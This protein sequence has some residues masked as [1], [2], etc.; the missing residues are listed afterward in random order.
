MGD[1]FRDTRSDAKLPDA[2]KLCKRGKKKKEILQKKKH[3]LHEDIEP[4]PVPEREEGTIVEVLAYCIS[5][6]PGKD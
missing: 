3:D 4:L 2:S 5:P 1:N 6:W